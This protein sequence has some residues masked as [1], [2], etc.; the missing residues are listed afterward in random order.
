MGDRGPGGEWRK[1]TTELIVSHLASNLV[2]WIPHARGAAVMIQA[3]RV[4]FWLGMVAAPLW[5]A[6]GAAQQQDRGCEPVYRLYRN[7]APGTSLPGR[8]HI[9]T[10][11]AC[12]KDGDRRPETTYNGAN[13]EIARQ[14]FQQQPGVQVT[15]WCERE[16]GR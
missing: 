16:A 13:C 2:T 3:A 7:W 9:A 10:F 6:P 8:A 12:H 4:V 1:P 15:F 14:L 5:A 11:D